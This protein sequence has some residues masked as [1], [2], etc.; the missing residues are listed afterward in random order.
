[1]ENWFNKLTDWFLDL[2]LW[3][4]RMI[5]SFVADVIETAMSWVPEIELASLQTAL[6]GLGGEVLYFMN[7]FQAGYGITVVLG[8]LAA[9]FLLRRIPVIG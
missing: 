1:M 9:R 3:I 5:V 8:A 4:P 2:V 7:L 6:N